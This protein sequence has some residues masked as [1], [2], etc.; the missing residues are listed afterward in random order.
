MI[1]S[2][3]RKA[4]HCYPIRRGRS[5]FTRLLSETFPLK[6]GTV[7]PF[8]GDLQ[9]ELCEKQF[10]SNQIFWFGIF[11]LWEA[12]FFKQLIRPGMVVVDVGG[13]IGQYT[14]L[15]AKRVGQ[16]GQVHTFEPAS[17]NYSIIERNICRNGFQDRV[18]LNKMALTS[19]R[20]PG[21]MMIANDGGSN[22]IATPENLSRPEDAPHLE[23]IECETL[24]HYLQTH[25]ID[26]VD[27][28]KIDAEGCD[29]EVLKGAVNTLKTHGPL[30]F[31]EFA[32]RVLKKY[33][34]SSQDMLKFLLDL[35]YVPYEFSGQG[36]RPLPAHADLSR[37]K[38][39]FLKKES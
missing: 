12:N 9:I 10:V 39:L 3:I 26:R 36:V 15:A 23:E 14:L 30:L 18:V 21:Y 11:E 6:Q 2:M 7:I 13:N 25:R 35:G 8:D 16:Q 17:L 4:M 5:R 34:A 32:E 1:K 33:G 24:D 31:V 27:V 20:K 37:D 38:N 29:F 28:L 19:E 22:A